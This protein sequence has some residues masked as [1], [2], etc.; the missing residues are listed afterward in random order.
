MT[1][2]INEHADMLQQIQCRWKYVR[3]QENK[4]IKWVKNQTTINPIKTIVRRRK[5]IL[6]AINYIVFVLRSG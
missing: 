4:E 5:N 6:M 2:P 3:Y 1:E